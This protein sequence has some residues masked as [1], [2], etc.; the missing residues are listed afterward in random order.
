MSFNLYPSTLNYWANYFAAKWDIY[1]NTNPLG[2]N[3]LT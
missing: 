3:L 2:F 1:A